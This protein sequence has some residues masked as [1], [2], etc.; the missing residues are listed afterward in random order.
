M[1][2]PKSSF[3]LS[4]KWPADLPE[5]CPQCGHT[6]D[7]RSALEIGPGPTGRFLKHYAPWM[8]VVMMVLM[9][10]TKLSFLRLG[11]NGG[12]MALAA[13]V[14]LPSVVLSLLGGLL[15][16]CSRLFCHQCRHESF[17]ALP[18]ERDNRIPTVSE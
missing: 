7:I 17:H 16:S 4:P 3:S 10:A 9:F 14:V 18:K 6:Y 12:A 2:S 1:P 11:G 13:A 5:H 15:P 8:T